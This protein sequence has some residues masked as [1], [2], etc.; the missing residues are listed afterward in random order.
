MRN[1]TRRSLGLSLLLAALALAPASAEPPAADVTALRNEY[2]QLSEYL[3]KRNGLSDEDRREAARLGARTLAALEANPT[4]PALVAMAVQLATWSESE[5][6]LDAAYARALAIRADNDVAL[7]QWLTSLV[8]RGQAERALDEAASRIPDLMAMPRSATSVAEAY[9]ALNRFDEASAMLAALGESAS[10]REL[11]IRTKP[12]LLRLAELETRWAKEYAQRFRDAERGDNPTVVL[13]TSRGPIT[14][15]L[16]E[17]QA[18]ATVGAFVEFVEGGLYD[19]TRFHRFVPGVGLFGGD[20]NTKPGATGRAGTGTAGFRL[21]DESR[22][23]DRRDA[24]GGSVVMLKTPDPNRPGRMQENGASCSFAILIEPAEHLNDEF[25]VVGRVVDGLD[26]LGEVRAGDELLAAR[27]LAKRGR[28]YRAVRM[29]ELP[30]TGE[31]DL[32]RPASQSSSGEVSRFNAP[33][34]APAAK[35]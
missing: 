6:D 35:P 29:P 13:T 12:M 20:P 21:P 1:P 16:F 27:V 9:L 33:G 22:R 25:T 18:P 10:R 26:L 30:I 34:V 31:F 32:A 2:R 15:E 3:R 8:R 17:E 28:D 24:F 14:L 11:A 4:D 5:A 23:S 7:S 19:G